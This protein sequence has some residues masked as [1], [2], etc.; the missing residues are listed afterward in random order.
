MAV[1]ANSLI[2]FSPRETVFNADAKR[3]DGSQ[4]DVSE[5]AAARGNSTHARPVILQRRRRR[6]REEEE[7][8]G[9]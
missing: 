6:W 1:E 8:N 4:P 2:N 9:R 7:K 3:A 5:N